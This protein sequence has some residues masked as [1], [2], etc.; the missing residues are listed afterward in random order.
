MS[1]PIYHAEN[2][3]EAVRALNH[4]TAWGEGYIWPA[5]VSAVIARLQILAARLPQALNQAGRWLQTTSDEGSV[6]HD[7]G[8]DAAATV[9]RAVADLAAASQAAETLAARLD[10]AHQSTA[11]LTGADPGRRS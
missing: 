7:A 3:A 1:D 4:A 5:D 9:A 8:G 10:A 11:H 6:G 2:A